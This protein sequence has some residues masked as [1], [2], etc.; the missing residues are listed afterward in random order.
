MVELEPLSFDRE[1]RNVAR[2][3]ERRKVTGEP[4][5]GALSETLLDAETLHWLRESRAKD[6]LAASLEAWLLRLREQVALGPRRT[7]LASAQRTRPYPISEPEQARLPLAQMLALSL[8]MP[9]E[10]ALYLRNYFARS[11][12]LAELVRRLWEERQMF[13]E[14]LKT[15]LD[16]FEVASVATLPAARAFISDSRGAFETL[17]IAEPAQLVTTL[18][19]ESAAEGW[20]ARLSQRTTLDLL[21]DETWLHGLRLRPFAVPI[22]RGASSFLLALGQAGRAICDAACA[23]RSPFVLATDVHDLR[24]DSVGALLALLPLSNAFASKRLGVSANRV[25]DQQRALARAALAELRVLAYRVLLRDLLLGSTSR[26]K[27][28]LPEASVA[29]LGFELPVDAAGVFVRVRAR[30]SQ[31]FA[32]ALLAATRYELLVQVHDEDWFRNPRAIAELRAELSEPARGVFSA[33]DADA[34][35]SGTAAFLGRIQAAL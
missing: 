24:R 14:S 2:E 10:R 8:A 22:A 35:S 23:Q 20:P 26:L 1:L 28:E 25:R 13:A 21:G 6:P 7:E 5:T 27:S 17:G 11:S 29:A 12:E 32:G 18:L 31:R 16:S 15:S 3:L 9:R 34:L 19:A 33:P 30:D 4:L